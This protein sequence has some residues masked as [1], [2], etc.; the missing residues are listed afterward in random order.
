MWNSGR[1]RTRRSS[2]VQ[3]HAS[4][5]AST[6]G[7]QVAV[8][9]HRALGPAGGARRVADQRRDCRARRPRRRARAAARRGDRPRAR[10]AGPPPGQRLG[11]P[12]GPLRR[13]RSA[14]PGARCRWPGGRSPR[15]GSRCWRA[16]RRG[17]PAARRRGRRPGRRT[18]RP[19][20][21]TRSPGCSPAAAEA[22]RR[23]PAERA[24]SSAAVSHGEP[25]S[26]RTGRA[27]RS[28]PAGRPRGGQRSTGQE[29][30]G[31]VGDGHARRQVPGPGRIG[32]PGVGGRRTGRRRIGRRGE[33]L[34]HRHLTSSPRRSVRWLVLGWCPLARWPATDRPE[35]QV[36]AG[37]AGT[38][39][40]VAPHT[41]GTHGGSALARW[42]LDG[43]VRPEGTRH[44]D[45]E[46]VLPARSGSRWPGRGRRA[47]PSGRRRPGPARLAGD[48]G[49][50]GP[51]VPGRRLR[52]HPRPPLRRSRRVPRWARPRR[53][54]R[55]CPDDDR[56]ALVEAAFGPA[57]PDRPEE[58][59]TS[60]SAGGP[61]PRRPA[62]LGRRT[63]A[64]LVDLVVF[65]APTA[66]LCVLV[67]GVTVVREAA[68][69]DY[70]VEVR[71]IVIAGVLALGYFGVLT[72]RRGRAAGKAL[73][74]L[75]VVD[76][77]HGGPIGAVRGTA[78]FIAAVGLLILVH[79]ARPRRRRLG[80]GRP[81]APDA[82]RQAG[83]Q[84]RRA[85][86][87]LTGPQ[88]CFVRLRRAG[89]QRHPPELRFA[90]AVLVAG[91]ARQ[92]EPVL[93]LVAEDPHLVGARDRLRRRPRPRQPTRRRPG[94]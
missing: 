39:R 6:R 59:A 9:E 83:G 7:Q 75:R 93:L 29:P 44:A 28:R 8:A 55:R 88:R 94:R 84:R 82:A 76:A 48:P 62:P 85:C 72:G 69:T 19:D 13:R 52:G 60:P 20:I 4:S 46:V 57:L 63:V 54:W 1:A 77:E 17:R 21:S 32:S 38:E 15:A 79:R 30:G 51:L 86:P 41:V 53:R 12:P 89:S 31:N 81:R 24:S 56:A 70:R 34:R 68:R 45:D 87:S 26:R 67:G 50:R 47:A 49:R 64:L 92:H 37:E 42:W 58:R 73:T 3:R 80:D 11:A 25:A 78:R 16:P 33:R 22:G 10:P 36:H 14:R 65:G 23:P 74:G 71:G 40:T 5:S 90:V 66:V 91:V 18:G 27:G 35:Q 61:A 2:A 43:T